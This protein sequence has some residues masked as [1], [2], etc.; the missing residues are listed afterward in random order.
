MD[1][2]ETVHGMALYLSYLE[3]LDRSCTGREEDMCRLVDAFKAI[4]RLGY[5]DYFA[6]RRQVPQVFGTNDHVRAAWDIGYQSGAT[7][8]M[9]MLCNCDCDRNVFHTDGQ[10]VCARQRMLESDMQ[11]QSARRRSCRG[12]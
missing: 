6:G 12:E 2:T 8:A 5:E 1:D 7:A 11:R 9:L 4:Q 10:R 3:S